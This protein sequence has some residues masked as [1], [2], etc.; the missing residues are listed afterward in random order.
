MSKAAD[1]V[2]IGSTIGVAAAALLGIAS[3]TAAMAADAAH[4]TVIELYQSQGCSS[5][6][7]AN[8]NVLALSN[9]P[10]VLALSFQVTYWD[11]L[12]W[13]DTF[14]K[15]QYTDRQ[16]DYARAFRHSEVWTPQV[17]V[18]GRADVVG[19]RKGQIEALLASADRGTGGPVVDIAGNRATISGKAFGHHADVWLVRYDPNIVQV[20]V[21]A[22]ENGGRTLPH[23]N[24]V[25]ELVRIGE[26][27]GATQ[28]YTL[29]AAQDGLK[30]AVLVQDGRG[31]PII[32]AGRI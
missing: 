25:R 16:W 23:K 21:R 2:R 26:W 19:S 29:P 5:C 8:A 22:G 27:E 31:G 3:T 1:L 15:P 30:T 17:V 14:A 13:K 28:S 4:P 18:N 24:I 11:S 32:A 10:D 6:P 20:A 9:R 7:P 12:G